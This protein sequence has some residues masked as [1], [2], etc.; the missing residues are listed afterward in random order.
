M[1]SNNE[2]PGAF[3]RVQ[4][5]LNTAAH[6][7]TKVCDFNIRLKRSQKTLNFGLET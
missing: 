2:L 7:K 4:I 5:S 3:S 1:K 6:R